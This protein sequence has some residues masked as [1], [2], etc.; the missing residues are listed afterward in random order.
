MPTRYPR[1]IQD[2]ADL[3]CNEVLEAHRLAFVIV[4]DVA[5]ARVVFQMVAE[6]LSN[7]LDDGHRCRA[8][9][10]FRG[11]HLALVHRPD[12]IQFLLLD[13]VVLPSQTRYLTLSQTSE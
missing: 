1:F 6:S 4:E 7:G 12:D 9:F 11:G 10:R 2:G 5:V 8:R 13:V 3:L